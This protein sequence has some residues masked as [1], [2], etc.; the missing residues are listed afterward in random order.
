MREPTDLE[1]WHPAAR[2][3]ALLA[4]PKVRRNFIFVFV[5]GLAVT[6]G[7]GLLVTPKKYAPW[8]FFASWAM[9]GFLSYC[10]V[11]VMSYPMFWVFARSTGYYG[12]DEWTGGYEKDVDVRVV[13]GG[14]PEY[15]DNYPEPVL[16]DE[17]FEAKFP[18]GGGVAPKVL[19]EDAGGES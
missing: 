19:D 1:T 8:D 6:A 10:T 18:P 15:Q 14:E 3:F 7:L 4:K 12:E 9:W 2:P 16:L 17:A 13:P 5:I 11:V